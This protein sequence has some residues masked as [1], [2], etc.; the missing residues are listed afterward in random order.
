MVTSRRSVL[1]LIFFNFFTNIL[2]TQSRC[3]FMKFA[4][5]TT[6][7]VI[8]NTEKNNNIIQEALDEL[9]GWSNRG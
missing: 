1:E 8:V 6:L 5:A 2:E 3:V 9:E 7:G 4:D